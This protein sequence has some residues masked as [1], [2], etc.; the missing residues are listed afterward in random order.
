MP[1]TLNVQY[2]EVFDIKVKCYQPFAKNIQ[3]DGTPGNYNPLWWVYKTNSLVLNVD[4]A[5][6]VYSTDAAT[7]Q[8]AAANPVLISP[9][10]VSTATPPRVPMM[11]GEE[12]INAGP[13]YRSYLVRAMNFKFKLRKIT[14]TPVVFLYKYLNQEEYLLGPTEWGLPNDTTHAYAATGDWH[15]IKF[16]RYI[17]DQYQVAKTLYIN[18]TPWKSHPEQEVDELSGTIASSGRPADPS[19]LTYI[20]FALFVVKSTDDTDDAY[21]SIS[22]TDLS[23]V[24]EYFRVNMIATLWDREPFRGNEIV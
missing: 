24:F 20:V 15:H 16:D 14:A 22:T 10:F 12:M 7:D 3:A 9:G 4:T 5:P 1:R 11:Y 18:T 6:G 19:T 13:E 8:V 17:A 21:L 23:M 2:P